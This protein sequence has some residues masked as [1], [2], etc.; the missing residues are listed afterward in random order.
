MMTGCKSTLFRT[1]IPGAGRREWE[2][3]ANSTTNTSCSGWWSYS[4]VSS[5]IQWERDHW[6]TAS[7]FPEWDPLPS[8]MRRGCER[9]SARQKL[10]GW[11]NKRVGKTTVSSTEARL[12]SRKFTSWGSVRMILFSWFVY[13]R[14]G[15]PSTQCR[16]R[17]I[18]PS[19]TWRQS[20]MVT[21]QYVWLF[22]GPSN[23][24]HGCIWKVS[25]TNIFVL[26]QRRTVW[27]RGCWS[28]RNFDEK[29]DSKFGPV[30][31]W[32]RPAAAREVVFSHYLTMVWCGFRVKHS[33][34][35]RGSGQR[36]HH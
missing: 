28:W 35:D 15:T 25:Q 20:K 7:E 9:D 27:M 23:W 19:R 30:M 34:I 26:D 2:R 36:D 14:C 12:G 21:V 1:E 10:H 22:L 31:E 29:I 3:A 24:R 11:S 32:R 4:K 33:W 5:H 8:S 6:R 16:W 18:P 17:D 13:T